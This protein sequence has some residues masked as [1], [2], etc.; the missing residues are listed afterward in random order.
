MRRFS[1]RAS[2]D[3]RDRGDPI[4]PGGKP[5]KGPPAASAAASPRRRHPCPAATRSATSAA[6]SAGGPALTDA[7]ADKST[8]R[9]KPWRQAPRQAPRA[10]GHRLPRKPT[11]CPAAPVRCRASGLVPLWRPVCR[12]VSCRGRPQAQALP[13]FFSSKPSTGQG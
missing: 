11:T 5:Q 1:R 10:R 6:P 7:P 4:G 9:R 12:R 13:G 8:R 3:M 2:S